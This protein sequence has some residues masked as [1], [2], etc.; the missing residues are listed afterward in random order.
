MKRILLIGIGG[1]YNYGC[2]AIVRGTVNI[3]RSKW[4]DC[5]II[6]ATPRVEDDRRRLA[7]CDVTIVH[8]PF[9]RYS[10]KNILRKLLSYFGYRWQPC[11]E[12]LSLLKNIDAVYSIGGDIFTLSPA[13]SYNASLAKFGMIAERK[14]I[15][16]VL[17]GASVGPFTANPKA[18]SFFKRHLSQI[19]QIVAREQGTVDYLASIGISS[20]VTLRPDPAFFVAPE[21]H[22][23]ND[24]PKTRPV[25]GINL[26]PL[27]VSYTG[28]SQKEAIASQAHSIAR[29]ITECNADVM[30]IPHVVC[31]FNEGDDDLRYLQKIKKEIPFPASRHVQIIEND[32]GFIGIKK[33]II[34]CNII[35]SARMHCAVNAMVACVPTILVA[36]SQ[37]AK[38]MTNFVYGDYQQLIKIDDFFSDHLFILTKEMIKNQKSISQ[39]LKNKMGKIFSEHGM[40]LNQ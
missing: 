24:K 34:K 21:I 11:L 39:K 15:P 18:E 30:L 35:I 23:N 9:N 32:H 20:N 8:R 27:S 36:Y 29:L 7:D 38:G 26:S 3:L 5:E 1:V 10:G 2:E 25:I 31:S 14:K 28:L 19:S 40:H 17:W 13:G 4:P 22:T 37:K 12:D 16:Y 6:Y 33:Y